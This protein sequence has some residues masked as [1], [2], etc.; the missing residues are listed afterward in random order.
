[1]VKHVR[2]VCEAKSAADAWAA[3]AKANADAKAAVGWLVGLRFAGVSRRGVG[4]W[5]WRLGGG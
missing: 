3:E 5:G 2:P 4:G 1:M